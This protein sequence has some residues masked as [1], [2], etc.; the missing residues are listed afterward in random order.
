MTVNFYCLLPSFVR[1]RHVC[2]KF[3]PKPS[4]LENYYSLRVALYQHKKLITVWLKGVS[5]GHQQFLFY[6]MGNM[7]SLLGWHSKESILLLVFKRKSLVYCIIFPMVDS[8]KLVSPCLEQLTTSERA[9]YTQE[10]C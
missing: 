4:L 7:D 6:F 2:F 8:E 3:E 10:S 5:R 9:D 1:L